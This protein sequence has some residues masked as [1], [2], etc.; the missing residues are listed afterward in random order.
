M[1]ENP[2]PDSNETVLGLDPRILLA[3]GGKPPPWSPEA[4]GDCIGHY[5]LLEQIGEGGF[6]AVWLA[7]QHEPVRRRVALK[8]IKPGMD[9]AEVIARFE[10]ERQ[11]LALMDHPNIAKVFDG[12]AT[13][14]GRP[15]FV[16][17]LVRGVRITDYCDEHKLPTAGRLA[18]FIAVCQAVQH[19]HQ[20]GIIHRDLKPSNILVTLQDGLPVPKVIDF[21]VA[22]ATQQNLTDLTLFTRLDQVI[23]T[24]L[25]MSPEQARAGGLD[26]DTRSDI[27]SLGVL[28]YEMLAGRTPFDPVE[29]LR[30]GMDEIRRIICEEE[31]P[32]PSTALSSMNPAARTTIA[33]R[34]ELDPVKLAG[35]LRGDLD[36]IVMKA[37]EKD[38][39]RRYETASALGADIQRFLD[40]EPVLA[41]PPGAA[42]RFRKFTRRNKAAL[43]VAA[44]IAAVL[45]AATAVS[46]WQA[47]LAIAAR[48]DADARARAERAAKEDAEA[49]TQFV[50]G[51]FQSSDPARDGRKITVA[52]K[53]DRAAKEL[54]RDATLPPERKAALQSTLGRTYHALDL[55]PEAIALLEKARDFWQ[56]RHGAEHRETILVVSDL[57]RSYHD[58]GRRAEAL[59]MRE[60][61]LANLRKTAGP[62]NPLTIL[63]M[64]NLAISLDDAGHRQ[65]ALALREEAFALSREVNGP[66]E[67]GTLIAMGNLALSYSDTG[68]R[69]E[70]LKLE[71]QLLA[72]RRRL[73]GPEHAYT[74][75]AASNLA[76]SLSDAGRD[77]EA[78]A[79]REEI[80]TLC[81]KV[82]GDT[83]IETVAAMSNLA[84]SYHDA[85]RNG[86]AFALRQDVLQQRRKVPGPEH[87]NTIKAMTSLANSHETT[88]SLDEAL[89]LEAEA[90]ALS[91][92]VNGPDHPDTLLI[93]HNLA[94]FHVTANRHDEA[95]KLQEEALPLMRKVLGPEDPITLA[96]MRDLAISLHHA[97]RDAEVLAL[98][99]ELVPLNRKVHG[100]EHPETLGA[101]T[102]LAIGYGSSGRLD[103][104]IKLQEE[105]LAIKRRVLPPGHPYRGTALRNLAFL[106]HE[107]GRDADIPALVKEFQEWEKHFD[108]PG[109]AEDA[110]KQNPPPDK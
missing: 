73:Y 43:T 107:T 21:G 50:V 13:P 63:A 6:G 75:M 108:T 61:V 10:Q 32:R 100:P 18:L 59:K 16:M 33:R 76:A 89:K 85:G 78:L 47:R 106:Y 66:E 24:P 51:V 109:A 95:L 93:M 94:K 52:E 58:A 60:E 64:S 72:L 102:N 84:S 45:V 68:R 39:T 81:R 22:K 48:E 98:Q 104:A 56:A 46:V 74:L 11:A 34:R 79:M 44:L 53:L 9:T 97:G 38:R 31:P 101:M 12:G 54:D 49:I 30:H 87:P 55:Q 23:G 92:K 70:A 105:S 69:K 83:H 91:R 65:E 96:T 77:K 88:G 35:L 17:E 103:E 4:S 42:Y 40:D 67:A 71:E 15:F 8:I 27:F 20:K 19:A 80:L 36:W 5:Q 110:P 57:A 26:I 28:L 1:P 99:E 25:Y 3:R 62:K 37:M 86:E 2:P 14:L 41:T 82:F 29:L 90:L 7:E